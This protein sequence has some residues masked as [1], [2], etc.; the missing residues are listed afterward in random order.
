MNVVF[1]TF[2]LQTIL[3]K[4][5]HDSNYCVACSEL[6]TDLAKDDPGICYTSNAT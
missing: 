4:D 3:L 6:D 5:K 2:P 1:F